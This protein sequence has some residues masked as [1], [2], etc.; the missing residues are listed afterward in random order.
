MLKLLKLKPNNMKLTRYLSLYKPHEDMDLFFSV[1]GWEPTNILNQVQATDKCLLNCYVNEWLH[2]WMNKNRV[3]G[4]KTI[5]R[6][7]KYKIFLMSVL[8]AKRQAE[9]SMVL[10]TQV[11]C[12]RGL[13]VHFWD[14]WCLLGH[15]NLSQTGDLPLGRG[16]SWQCSALQEAK[17]ILPSLLLTLE[18][19]WTGAEDFHFNPK[20]KPM[21]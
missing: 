13:S 8:T 6:T 16:T 11:E 9:P 15:K 17:A 5:N 1:W 12:T 20:I 3:C 2:K 7:E 14:V 21:Q 10:D 18:I 19:L 4:I